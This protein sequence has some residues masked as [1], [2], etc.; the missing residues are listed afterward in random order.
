MSQYLNG[1]LTSRKTVL[2]YFVIISKQSQLHRIL[3]LAKP[4][5]QK[6]EIDV[7]SIIFSYE[8]IFVFIKH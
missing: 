7:L 4:N 5:R 3:I 8:N 6:F 2:Y 1:Q